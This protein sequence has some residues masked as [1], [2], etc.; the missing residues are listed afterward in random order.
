MRTRGWIWAGPAVF[1]L[2]DAEEVL[3]IESWLREHGTELPP[4]VHRFLGVT[5]RQFALAVLLLFAGFLAA[6]AHAAWR[7]QRARASLVFLLLA[8]TLV[9]NG[10]T[11][12][13]QAVLFRG[14]TPGVVTALL[15]VLPYGYVLGERLR[16]SGLATR[17]MWAVAIAAGT[18]VQIPLAALMLSA[19]Q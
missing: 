18:V 16:A 8:G 14:Y 4:L 11:H 2:H 9:G 1:L 19:V 13:A 3:T 10:L 17:R 12:I 15:V 5:A 6:A 7:A